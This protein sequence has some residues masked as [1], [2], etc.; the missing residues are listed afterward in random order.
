MR[1]GLPS[2]GLLQSWHQK[3]L[4]EGIE[5]LSPK[6]KGPPSMSKKSITRE[7]ALERENELLRAELAFIKKIQ[8]L[9]MDV[10][11]RL[12]NEMPE[13]STNSEASSD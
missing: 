1:Y 2:G 9:G 5:D 4:R 11:E 7:Q 6:K 13:S 12:Q 10:P 8:A 3:L